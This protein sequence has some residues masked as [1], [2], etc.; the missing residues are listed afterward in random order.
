MSYGRD[1]VIQLQTLIV[2][3]LLRMKVERIEQFIIYINWKVSVY[4]LKIMGNRACITT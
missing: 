1:K 4:G 2:K 3:Y